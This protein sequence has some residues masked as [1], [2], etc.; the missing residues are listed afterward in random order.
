M[1]APERLAEALPDQRGAVGIGLGVHELERAPQQGLLARGVARLVGGH[2]GVAQE[3]Q[4][5]DPGKRHGV[6]HPLPE[7]EHALEERLRLGEG[8][9][10][11]GGESGSRRG[12]ERP[13]LVAGRPPVVRD[14]SGDVRAALAALDALLEGARE[15]GVHLRPLSRQQVLVDHLTQQRVA[16]AIA[17]VANGH[18]DVARH[19]L[20]QRV[21]Q[22]GGVEPRHGSHQRVVGGGLA[23]E[24]ADQLLRARRQPLH[25]QHQRVA[26]G[27]GQAAAPVETRGEDLLRVERVALAA[28]IDALH[29]LRLGAVTGD[30]LELLGELGRREAR[31]VDQ[32]RVGV[33]GQLGEQ[34][35]QRVAAVELIRAVGAHHQQALVTDR[36]S[37]EADEGAGGAVRPVEVLDH[38]HR[39]PVLR[40][41]VEHGEQRLEDARLGGLT[42]AAILPK[43]RED[44]VKSGAERGRERVQ[45]RVAVADERAQRCEQRRVGELVLAQL[46]AVTGE[47]TRPGLARVP[48]QLVGKPRLA[49]A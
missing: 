7:C 10:A 29:E 32:A 18:H 25:P 35:P 27:R 8:I 11:L 3:L 41:A 2:G 22:V 16:E 49:D 23:G 26:Q 30:P 17:L 43:S 36:A 31:Q 21:A 48:D 12:R 46:H 6:G 44:R 33:A 38:E 39:R 20:A 45:G 40:E 13:R 24:P 14:L 1:L 42:R 4:L 34:R 28:R 19:R 5:V 37:E 47:H 15:S 9:H